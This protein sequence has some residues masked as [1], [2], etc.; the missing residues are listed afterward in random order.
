MIIG[1]FLLLA[2]LTVIGCNIRNVC[3]NTQK[4]SDALGYVFL[5]LIGTILVAAYMF[6]GGV[7]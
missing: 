7:Q 6:G 2:G 1:W 5:G 3:T 4:G